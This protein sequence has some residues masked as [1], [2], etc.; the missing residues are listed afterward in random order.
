MGA[1]ERKT[2][3]VAMAAYM[4]AHPGSFP[5]SVRRPGLGEGV[6]HRALAAGMGRVTN[7]SSRWEVAMLGG[8]IAARL[9]LG[10]YGIDPEFIRPR[11]AA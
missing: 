7:N 4:K 11:D 3:D 2:K 10:S 1:A 6:S 5:D 9:G 8:V